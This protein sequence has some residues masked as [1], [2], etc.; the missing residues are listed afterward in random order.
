MTNDDE[1][2]EAE[3]M[4]HDNELFKTLSKIYPSYEEPE[5]EGGRLELQKLNCKDQKAKGNHIELQNFNYN[6]PE[7]EGG[8]LELQIFDYDKICNCHI[9][10]GGDDKPYVDITEDISSYYNNSISTSQLVLAGGSPK[11]QNTKRKEHHTEIDM[12]PY[13]ELVV[14]SRID[15]IAKDVLKFI[16]SKNPHILKHA[17]Q[18][19]IDFVVSAIKEGSFNN[20]RKEDY[21]RVVASVI[22]EHN[23]TYEGFKVSHPFQ[24]ISRNVENLQNKL[25]ELDRKLDEHSYIKIIRDSQLQSLEYN[26][27]HFDNLLLT[28]D[29]DNL[30]HPLIYTM[31]FHKL[32]LVEKLTI[33]SDAYS[34]LKS[35]IKCKPRL[36]SNN[37]NYELSTS[38]WLEK[39]PVLYY[40]KNSIIDNEIE[41]VL[42]HV[43]LKKSIID[44]RRGSLSSEACTQLFNELDKTILYNS[45]IASDKTERLLSAFCSVFAI[46]PIQIY[47]DS[48]ISEIKRCDY[49]TYELSNGRF[50]N[51]NAVKLSDIFN[52]RYDPI[53]GRIMMRESSSR[54]DNL[55]YDRLRIDSR[56]TGLTV[57]GTAI[58]YVK[59][60]IIKPDSYDE[61]DDNP[62][63]Y[64]TL[65][66]FDIST[67]SQWDIESKTYE[68]K[69]VMCHDILTTADD[70]IS[71]VRSIART[72]GYFSIVK[73]DKKYYKYKP[74]TFFTLNGLVDI[75]KNYV[76][77]KETE[78]KEFLERE[79]ELD[80][81]KNWRD[82]PDIPEPNCSKILAEIRPYLHLINKD[83]ED[84]NNNI[85]KNIIPILYK[86]DVARSFEIDYSNNMFRHEWNE[87]GHEE[88]MT[89]MGTQGCVY[90]YSE[91]YE[92][93][94]RRM[95]E[96]AFD[97][98][99]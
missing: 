69:S 20:L 9:A 67:N 8:Q 63:E 5:V 97:N 78:L 49:F 55:L 42:N 21:H 76:D 10:A 73:S 3:T 43:L 40:H 13:G 85:I 30:V 48:P 45:S 66:E 99:V 41:R 53:K 57:N 52:I 75:K 23:R 51:A 27:E 1:Y 71:S 26:C 39:I 6:E 70:M 33:E 60:K 54:I 25:D 96:F 61:E 22:A 47:T 58:L 77:K 38:R 68:L 62:K 95:D 50:V 14:N 59:R 81:L 84:N 11:R 91:G 65:S 64:I 32:P 12:I 31:F 80:K 35:V 56:T 88:A 90:V 46:K 98:I 82:E 28:F 15:S 87:I 4:N 92:T 2:L 36:K 37:A 93:Y 7:V 94:K 79:G 17:T 72:S 44:F 86:A 74:S 29:I 18:L 24:Y 89:L 19:T 34:L 16:Y 83:D